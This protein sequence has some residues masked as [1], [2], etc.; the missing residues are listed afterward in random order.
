MF[1]KIIYQFARLKSSETANF[2]K[3]IVVYWEWG[4]GRV[5]LEEKHST[6]LLA[7]VSFLPSQY[8]GAPVLSLFWHYVLFSENFCLESFLARYG[9]CTEAFKVICTST[10]ALNFYKKY[11][12]MTYDLLFFLLLVLSLLLLH[13]TVKNLEGHHISEG[14][15]YVT[16]FFCS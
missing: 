13:F 11:L 15:M 8:F 1:E 14:F 6:S 12:S 7:F 16:V 3:I 5:N 10:K 2:R 4:E 9:L